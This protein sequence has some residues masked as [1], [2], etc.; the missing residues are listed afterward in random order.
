MKFSVADFLLFHRPELGHI[1]LLS[2]N[3]DS[4]SGLGM[5]DPPEFK[6]PQLCI[7][8]N[9]SCW[10]R[11][12]GRIWRGVLHGQCRR[13]LQL[14]TSLSSSPLPVDLLP[15]SISHKHRQTSCHAVVTVQSQ[16]LQLQVQLPWPFLGGSS[17]TMLPPSETHFLFFDDF[18]QT[19]PTIS[20]KCFLM[21]E[22]F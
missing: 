2:V 20:F 21:S 7:W 10:E 9:E 5:C 22:M 3:K 1:V 19:P 17:G 12:D 13:S 14:V 4:F 8:T 11:R 6:G 16:Y 18:S 15:G